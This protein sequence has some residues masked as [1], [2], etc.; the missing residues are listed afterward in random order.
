MA[1]FFQVQRLGQSTRGRYLYFWRYPSFL[2]IQCSINLAKP[3]AENKLYPSSCFDMILVCD[4]H[5]DTD[6]VP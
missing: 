3:C 2:T 1:K 4:R 6:T 5:T